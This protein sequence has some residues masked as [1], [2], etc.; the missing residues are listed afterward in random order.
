MDRCK[1]WN[2]TESLL[3]VC[4]FLFT[5]N[6]TNPDLFAQESEYNSILATG[7]LSEKKNLA[8][9]LSTYKIKSLPFIKR[10]LDD[11]NYWNRIAGIEAAENF[12]DV[13][14]D[15]KI[16]NL[17]LEDHMT[18]TESEKYIQV[19][20]RKMEAKFLEAY[21]NQKDSRNKEKLSKLIVYPLEANTRKIIL[22]E[23]NHK[24]DKTR[25]RSLTILSNSLN[26][27][28]GMNP[29]DELIRTFT[30]DSALRLTVLD[31]IQKNGKPFDLPIFTE[32]LDSE[33]S[34]F[35]ER[36]IALK[37]LRD[38]GTI[39]QQRLYYEKILAE[40]SKQDSL[41]FV[42]MQVLPFIKS[43]NI[44]QKLCDLSK[45]NTNQEM[46]MAAGLALI[47]Y[48]SVSNLPCLEKIAI[49]T[50]DPQKQASLGDAIA[51]I[52][53]FGIAGFKNIRDE[54]IRRQNFSLNQGRIQEHLQY[55][56]KL[57]KE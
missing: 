25:L 36:A 30:K 19:R 39:K 45:T 53:T 11:D 54:Q 6:S 3:L 13:E 24:D 35:N 17:Y 43:E 46:R 37:T 52:L 23:L 26:K 29:D 50:I 9:K 49:E 16:L 18:T 51:V 55:L 12:A 10:L 1:N 28:Q 57:A 40:N 20:Y 7:G 31:Y 22:E 47:Y 41:K 4:L 44:R 34:S 2:S 42:A 15:N 21:S 14:L 27:R 38:W 56:R 33:K 48:D 8:I 32:I 5:I